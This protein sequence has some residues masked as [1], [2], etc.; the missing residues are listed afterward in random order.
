MDQNKS[1]GIDRVMATKYTPGNAK[2]VFS[3]VIKEFKIDF[4]L[5]V[6]FTQWPWKYR[7]IYL[8]ARV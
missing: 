5:H 3:R 1:N 7:Y 8:N 4:M 6:Y 2:E